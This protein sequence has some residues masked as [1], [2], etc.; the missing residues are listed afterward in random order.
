MTDPGGSGSRAAPKLKLLQ[1]ALREIGLEPNLALLVKARKVA[2]QLNAYQVISRQH[3][4][5]DAQ[6]AQITEER[7]QR[8]GDPSLSAVEVWS[9]ASR[10]RRHSS[11]R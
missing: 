3:Y 11:S 2:R 5:T 4:V 6:F 8:F 10:P 7:R 1:D 9:L